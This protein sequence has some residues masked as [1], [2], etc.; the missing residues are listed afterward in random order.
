MILVS[1]EH[2]HLFIDFILFM[3]GLV[4]IMSKNQIILYDDYAEVVLE[5]KYKVEVGRAIIDLDDLNKVKNYRWH[6]THKG[7][8]VTKLNN[9]DIRLH[10]YIMD[11]PNGM[12]VDHINGCKYDNRKTNLRVCTQTENNRNRNKYKKNASS[13]YKGVFYDKKKGKWRALIQINKKSKHI[14]YYDSELEASIEYDKKAIM[15]HKEYANLNH[16]IESYIDYILE[17]G[18]NPNDFIR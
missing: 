18:L 12:V 7:Y 17:L 1:L 3:K 9:K 8:I 15:Y 4:Y 2:N 16:P 13:I 14:G 5:N 6:M 10:R 11:C